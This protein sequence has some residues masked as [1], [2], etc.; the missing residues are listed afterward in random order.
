MR[1]DSALYWRAPGLL[2][3]WP[4]KQAA[5]MICT[6]GKSLWKMET[7][8]CDRGQHF[9]VHDYVC[10]HSARG[11]TKGGCGWMNASSMDMRG[12]LK[13]LRLLCWRVALLTWPVPCWQEADS[14]LHSST[15]LES[16]DQEKFLGIWFPCIA[17]KKRRRN[18]SIEVDRQRG[19]LPVL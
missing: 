3:K 11:W 7:G 13:L 18:Q 19:K 4:W 5:R 10:C 1:S 9:S 12:E 6:F 2:V 16:V 14:W 15:E 17:K 8:T